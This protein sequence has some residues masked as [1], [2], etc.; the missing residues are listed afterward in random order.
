MYQSLAELLAQSGQTIDPEQFKRQ[1]VHV[2]N[3]FQQSEIPQ[4]GEMSKPQSFIDVHTFDYSYVTHNHKE[5]QLTNQ[6]KQDWITKLIA[7]MTDPIAKQGAHL[8]SVNIGNLANMDRTNNKSAE[9][10][11][12]LLAQYIIQKDRSLLPM[13]EEQLMD[14]V[15]LGQCAQGRTTRLW[16]LLVSL[17]K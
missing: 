15:E 5:V 10:I 9:D 4:M 7:M 12:V 16:Q 17:P 2:T 14:M 6:E 3:Q 11:L 13:V 1:P 8:I